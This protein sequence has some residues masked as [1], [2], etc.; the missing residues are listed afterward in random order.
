MELRE[1]VQ[2]SLRAIREHGLR[3]ALTVVGITIGIAAVVTFVTLGASLQ[4][5][6][7]GE[8]SGDAPPEMQATVGPEGQQGGPPGASTVPAFTERDL[9]EIRSLPDVERAVP[10]GTV[11]IA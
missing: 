11:Q 7:V 10:Q 4:A 3:S 1:S 8:V 9:E 6:V 2:L 5:E